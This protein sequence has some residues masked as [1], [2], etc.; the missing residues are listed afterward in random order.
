MGVRDFELTDTER[1]GVLYD[2]PGE[3]RRLAVRV[4]YPAADIEGFE[5]RPYA[6][7]VE[8]ESTFPALA[9]QELGVPSFFYS[10]VR[11]VDTH[12]FVD[13]P[14]LDD[15]TLPV[16]FFHQGLNGYLS[17]NTV[18]MEHLASHGYVVFSVSHPYDSAPV[19]FNDGEVIAL[20]DAEVAARA[21]DVEHSDAALALVDQLGLRENG[22]TYEERFEGTLGLIELAR[23]VDDRVF[24]TSPRVWVE[25]ALFVERELVG[26]RAPI[27]DILAV[28]DLSRVGQVGMSFGGSTA[29]A[30]GYLDPRAAAVVNLD[31]SDHHQVGYDAEV[32]VA[33][34]MLYTDSIDTLGTVDTVPFGWNGFLYEPFETAGTRDDVVRLHLERVQHFGVTDAQLM[35][36]G[37]VHTMLAGSL[38]TDRALDAIN[39]VVRAFF[40]EHL[41]ATSIDFPAAQLDA[42][43][44]ELELHDVAPVR[45]LWNAKSSNRQAEARRA[46]GEALD[47]GVPVHIATR[48]P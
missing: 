34:L 38:D 31:G 24:D 46:L 4:W 11:H 5:R 9:T 12:S 40:D 42:H 3:P 19:V 22:Q 13:A 14:V 41:R 36:R 47:N 43:S 37:P 6:T 20:P 16:V 17:Q 39:D 32:P 44:G 25:D 27:R 29:A 45:D 26:D 18:L 23:V 8:L 2:P 7:E 21:G 33:L 10:H 30:L 1:T 28:I 35:S 48:N 15:G